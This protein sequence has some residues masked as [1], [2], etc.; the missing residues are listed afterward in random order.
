MK[1]RLPL[2]NRI[3]GSVVCPY[4]RVLLNVRD[5]YGVLTPLPFR[6]DTGADCT[7]IPLQVARREHLSFQQSR[8]SIAG[9]LVGTAT[10]FRDRIRVVLA[11]K[12]HDWPCD[13]IDLP[14]SPSGHRLDLL[15]DLP[16]LGRAGFLEEYAISIDSG[17]L[18]VT[19]LDF[20]RRWWRRR[21][22]A[23]WF[24][25]RMIHPRDRPL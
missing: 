2:Q 19:R 15:L 7:A 10:K 24:V 8:P 4:P 17:F 3:I 20:F 12:E 13:F 16:V 25:S 1:I 9:G 18:I 22:Q 5:S 21:L 14:S 23:F 6:I 11:G